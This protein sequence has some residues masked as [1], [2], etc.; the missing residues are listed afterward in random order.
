MK[1]AQRPIQLPLFEAAISRLRR[2]PAPPAPPADTANPAK[3]AGSTPAAAAVA[4]EA[5][6]V[7]LRPRQ[8]FRRLSRLLDGRLASLSLT[9]NRRTILTV[10]AAR[11]EP[12]PLTLRLHR[13]FLDAPEETLEAVAVFARSPRGTSRSKLALATIREHFS[14]HCGMMPAARQRRAVARPQ[15]EVFDLKEICNALNR[16]YFDNKLRVAITW[17]KGESGTGAKCRRRRVQ[18]STLQLG[19]YSFEDKLIRLHRVLDQPR[20]PRYV[21]EAVVYHELLHA[22]IP[23]EVR[24]GRR[25]VH[26]PEFRRRERLFR[27]LARAEAWVERN[28]RDLLRARAGL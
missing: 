17:G 7:D 23:P 3:R 21:V 13:S 16:E 8:L 4:P 24:N 5:P 26:T 25:Y 22:A 12:A 15:G 20:V 27:H 11:G 1:P 14:R 6:A 28:L 18:K 10:R 9:D 19:S 2:R